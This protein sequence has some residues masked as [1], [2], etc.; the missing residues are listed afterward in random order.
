MLVVSVWRE[1]RTIYKLVYPQY[2]VR[3]LHTSS[4]V[5][6]TCCRR[7]CFVEI[8]LAFLAIAALSVTIFHFLYQICSRQLRNWMS[9][10][11]KSFVPSV[12][13]WKDLGLVK[14]MQYFSWEVVSFENRTIASLLSTVVWNYF[15]F[16]FVRLF[17]QCTQITFFGRVEFYF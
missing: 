6:S 4:R 2:R 13:R 12:G 11:R 17:C 1:A 9:F 7:T 15:L 3:K 8:R 5:F 10:L 16:Y 14:Y